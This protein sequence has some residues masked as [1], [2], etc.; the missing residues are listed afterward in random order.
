MGRQSSHRIS[1]PHPSVRS[2]TRSPCSTTA[3]APKTTF[4]APSFGSAASGR[5]GMASR[6][7]PAIGMKP[8]RC[9]RQICRGHRRPPNHS[10]AHSP[11]ASQAG[12]AGT[13]LPHLRRAS[14]RQAAPRSD[15]G[16]RRSAGQ[17]AQFSQPREPD[18]ADLLPRWGDVAITAITEHML[19]DWIADDYRVEDR[20][21]TVALAEK[22]TGESR[23]PRNADRKVVWKKPSQTT[24]GNLDWALL[25]VW[26]EA[27]AAKVVERRKRP[28]IDKSLGLDGEPRAFIDAEGVQA[29]ANVMTDGWVAAANGH[30]T[31]M[32]RLLRCY[33]AMIAC[34]GIRA[35]LEAKRVLIGNV[36]F[37][38]QHNE[39]VILI[40]VFKRQGKHREPRSV[41]VYEGDPAFEVR[42]L[43][44]DHIA[45]RRSQ[46]ATEQDYLFAWPDGTFPV[47]RDVLDTVL[48]EAKALIDPRPRR[49]AWPIRSGI[50]SQRS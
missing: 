18:R 30:G 42:K 4:G 1:K 11:D 7:A 31:D 9:P 17:G 14:H 29:V 40:R 28:I 44:V 46:G 37:L 39:P 27:V 19:N 47:F 16:R 38:T 3:E 35:G 8:S 34:T 33:V 23:Q 48:T 49:S 32:K 21:A 5:R 41:I 36:R 43:L 12:G 26:Q 6:S 15:R 45:W 22:L 13:R 50:I 25:H 10:A 24:L 20:A 2:P